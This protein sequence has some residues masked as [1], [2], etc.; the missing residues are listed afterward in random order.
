MSHALGQYHTPAW[1]A[2]ELWEAFFHDIDADDT[3]FEPTC[4]DGRMLQAVP[5]HVPAFGC[6][7]DPVLAQAAR[8][9]TDR[10]VITGDVLTSEFPCKFNVIFGNPPFRAAF[11]DRLLDR[12]AVEMDDGLRC[13]MIVPAYF[14]QTPSRVLRWNRDWTLGAELLPRT[15]FPRLSKPI[16]FAL[17][18]KDP[19]PRMNGLRLYLEC[20]AMEDLK[21]S[22]RAELTKGLGLWFVVVDQALAQLGGEAELGAI[23]AAVSI[24]RPTDNPWWREKVRQTLQRKFV[25]RRRGVWARR[26]A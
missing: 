10:H 21:S 11:L 16:I 14:M 13:G 15:L 23:Y 7:I 9:R 8:D 19:L 26:A 4:G 22:V 3:V 25:N 6:E 20:A 17:F 2:R 18:T 24:K 5:D 1:A 12:L